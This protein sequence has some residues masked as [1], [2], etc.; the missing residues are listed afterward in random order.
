MLDERFLTT[1]S[2]LSGQQRREL[3]RYYAQL[4]EERRVYVHWQQRTVFKHLLADGRANAGK[5]GEA[6]YV[7]LLLA[8][9]S[10]WEDEQRGAIA[11]TNAT[12][13]QSRQRRPRKQHLRDSLEKRFMDALIQL[14]EQE[15]LSWREIA[16]QFKKQFRK[17]VS[18]TYLKKIYDERTPTLT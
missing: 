12:E 9:K 4:D 5:G 11:G 7:A 15:Q 6:N 3:V 14:R 2:G 17:Q 16:V 8:L 18:H 13:R 1:V 10:L